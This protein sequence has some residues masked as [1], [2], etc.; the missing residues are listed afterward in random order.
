MSSNDVIIGYGDS[1][2]WRP[3]MDLLHI[4]QESQLNNILLTVIT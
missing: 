4:Q 1:N 2:G 3:T